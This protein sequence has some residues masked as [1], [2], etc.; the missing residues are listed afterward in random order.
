MQL[1]EKMYSISLCKV[2]CER[3]LPSAKAWGR[4]LLLYRSKKYRTQTLGP[5]KG[6][7][8]VLRQGLAYL[9]FRAR[10]IELNTNLQRLYKENLRLSMIP[11]L[12]VQEKSMK[13]ENL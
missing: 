13:T 9:Q 4:S 7:L 2:L 5:K 10:K 1:L 6:I 8:I 11:Q 12:S 3:S